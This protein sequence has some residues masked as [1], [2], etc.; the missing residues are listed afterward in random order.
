MKKT[1]KKNKKKTINNRKTINKRK[2]IKGGEEDVCAICLDTLVNTDANITLSCNHTFHIECMTSA[3]KGSLNTTQCL[4]PF[5]RKQ[6]T[7]EEMNILG[8]SPT[9]YYTP[10]LPSTHYIDTLR[11][12]K[13][14]INR[15]LRAPTREPLHK[16]LDELD[17]F[18]G[19]D[20]LPGD[21][22]Y[23]TM[24][25]KLQRYE[26]SRL[27]RYQFIRITGV[28][29]VIPNNSTDKKYIE[30]DFDEEGIAEDLF[31]Y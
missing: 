3:C 7:T 14:Y 18:L 5:C 10:I 26:H 6:L 2:I 21:L 9:L 11:E 20:H 8:F 31:V 28:R 25:F 4:C 30:Y 27:T 24:E 16:L 15:K 29:E 1:F 12:F 22:F 23:R 13:Q 17:L 19:T